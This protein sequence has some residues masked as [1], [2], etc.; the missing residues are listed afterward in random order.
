MGEL[1]DK[2]NKIKGKRNQAGSPPYYVN[3]LLEDIV[4]K[5]ESGTGTGTGTGSSTYPIEKVVLGENITGITLKPNVW[6]DIKNT[7][8]FAIIAFSSPQEYYNINGNYEIFS[9]KCDDESLQELLDILTI[10]G[11]LIKTNELSGY[12]YKQN[13]S[14]IGVN[15][16][17]YFATNPNDSTDNRIKVIGIPYEGMEELELPIHSVERINKDNIIYKVSIVGME[18]STYF[19]NIPSDIEG[20][21]KYMFYMMGEFM[22]CYTDKPIDECESIFSD[23]F[24]EISIKKESSYKEINNVNEFV[25]SI[26]GPIVQSII[27]ENIYWNGDNIPDFTKMGVYTI[28]II[29]GVGCWTFKP[30]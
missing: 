5:V 1:K 24:G 13:I 6:Y 4:D 15:V 28:S 17:V 11:V 16:T 30:E 23:E 7:T 2:F 20:K 22:S 21:Y 29:D 3:E 14:T 18:M 27:M 19:I 26:N 12:E 10:G 25:F 8:G 9:A